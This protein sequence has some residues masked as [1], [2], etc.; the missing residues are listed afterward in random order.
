MG[1]G[2][3]GA[4]RGAARR[5]MRADA[6]GS[7]AQGARPAAAAHGPSCSTAGA[8]HAIAPA[9]C[10]PQAGQESFR[11][12]T[13][14]YY[15]GAAGALL[16]YDITRCVGCVWCCA[17]TAT[18][19][20]VQHSA[21]PQ[22][23][24]LQPPGELAGGR[25]AARQPQHDHHAHRQQVRPD[26]EPGTR[27]RAHERARTQRAHHAARTARPAL[28]HAVHA[29]ACMAPTPCPCPLARSTGAL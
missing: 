13:R 11:S 12:I 9:P 26:G 19:H 14:S 4:R 28:C 17:G 3:C 22:A 23:R 2:G 20:T 16:V 29:H 21:S 1:H 27:P 25:T 18:Q 24:D 5:T 10:A 8:L 7:R 15:R 6:P